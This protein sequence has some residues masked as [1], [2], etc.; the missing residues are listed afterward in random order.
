MDFAGFLNKTFATYNVKGLEIEARYWQAIVIIFLI[1]LL[2]FTLARMRYLY[3]HWN[4]GR[5][6]LSFL[7]YGFLLALILEGFLLIGGKTIITETLGWKNAPKPLSTALDAGRSKLINVLGAEDVS[8]SPEE[9]LTDYGNL[10]SKD[11]QEVRAV[12]CKP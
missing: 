5:S 1:F 3:V 7:F 8:A 6:S 2:L 9:I 11:A 12:I 4:L 10:T